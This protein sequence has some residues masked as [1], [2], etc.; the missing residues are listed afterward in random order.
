MDD[1]GAITHQ[2]LAHVFA[3][4]VGLLYYEVARDLFPGSPVHGT[5]TTMPER[6]SA[7]S[8]IGDSGPRGASAALPAG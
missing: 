5:P 6:S 7:D 8:P 4:S 1:D 3:A 2:L